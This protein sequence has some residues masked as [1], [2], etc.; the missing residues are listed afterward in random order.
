MRNPLDDPKVMKRL[1]IACFVLSII[2]WI[3]ATV[4]GWVYLVA[5]VS[6]LSQLTFTISL[7]PWIQGLRVEA[8]QVEEDIPDEVVERIIERTSLDLSPSVDGDDPPIT[9]S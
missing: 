9:S 1:A 5:Y 3:M 4:F 8:R 7:V 2:E 6:H